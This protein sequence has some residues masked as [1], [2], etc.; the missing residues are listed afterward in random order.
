ME[1]KPIGII[2]GNRLTKHQ[3]IKFKGE[4]TQEGGPAGCPRAMN[5][6]VRS[7]WKGFGT[8]TSRRKTNELMRRS[9]RMYGKIRKT[10]HKHVV[11]AWGDLVL[12]ARTQNLTTSFLFLYDLC[13]PLLASSRAGAWTQSQSIPWN[14][15]AK[16]SGHLRIHWALF[17][18]PTAWSKRPSPP[19]AGIRRCSARSRDWAPNR[20][21]RNRPGG[22]KKIE[23]CRPRRPTL[24]ENQ[25]NTSLYIS[26]CY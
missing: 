2:P 4:K 19:P 23:W 5:T 15:P 21:E 26:Y 12:T 8:R 13:L 24:C 10:K 16:G 17:Q 14:Q 11:L 18:C 3:C 9:Y 7:S 25:C 22:V 1:E 20:V 6:K